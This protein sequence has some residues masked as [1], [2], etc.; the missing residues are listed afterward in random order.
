M[1][2]HRPSSCVATASRQTKPRAVGP[3]L[4]CG[5][6]HGHFQHILD[7]GLRTNASAVVLLGDIEARRSL[8]LEFKPLLDQG[9]ELFFIPGNHDS[10]NEASWRW[11]FE[12]GQER[13][14]L[15]GRVGRL[16]DG[17]RI[18]GLGGV[19]RAAVWYPGAADQ[20]FAGS[21]RPART[22]RLL[23]Q[24][25]RPGQ[26]DRPALAHW[27]SIRPEDVQALASQR[28]DILV[29]HEAP[30]YHRH[31]FAIL[32]RLARAM[33]VR[34]TLHGHHHDRLDSSGRW[35][36]QGFKSHGVGLRGITALDADGNA[37]VV[38]AGELDEPRS[39]GPT[40][41]LEDQGEDA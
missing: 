36:I 20:L 35:A 30:G 29:T 32:D 2:R 15:Q 17:T 31:G 9:A 24:R 13:R 38:V 25:R 33:G 3:V 19:F 16:P 39:Q 5:D 8:D 22:Q 1:T 18:A 27:T 37:T 10:D 6:P 21:D 7:A 28:A 4:Y 12:D 11:L 14:N 23:A 40:V 41:T 26:G 34:A